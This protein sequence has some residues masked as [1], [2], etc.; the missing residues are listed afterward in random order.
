MSKEYKQ[1]SKK[2]KL[3]LKY[4]CVQ[5]EVKKYMATFE[6]DIPKVLWSHIEDLY[7]LMTIK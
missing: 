4:A 1:M 7:V 6:K 5:P 2:D 3:P